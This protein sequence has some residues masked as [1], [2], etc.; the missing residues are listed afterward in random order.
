M[1]SVFDPMTI[2]LQFIN[3]GLVVL[4]FAALILIIITCA[5]V[6]RY[7]NKKEKRDR[8]P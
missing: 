1:V 8:E 3:I 4:G 6:I 2:L 7:L 5:K